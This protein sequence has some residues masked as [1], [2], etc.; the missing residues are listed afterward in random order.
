MSGEFGAHVSGEVGFGFDHADT[1][2]DF[3]VD[4]ALDLEGGLYFSLDGVDGDLEIGDGDFGFGFEVRRD[5]ELDFFVGEEGE[6]IARGLGFE[7]LV[8]FAFNI[9]VEGIV[10]PFGDG[11]LF[12]ISNVRGLGFQPFALTVLVDKEYSVD[13]VLFIDHQ[14]TVAGWK[15]EWMVVIKLFRVKVYIL[16]RVMYFVVIILHLYMISRVYV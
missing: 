5:V 3:V 2:L 9:M 16:S 8:Y 1:G 11:L 13:L 6:V 10:L 12:Q 7:F 4:F 14:L 15:Y